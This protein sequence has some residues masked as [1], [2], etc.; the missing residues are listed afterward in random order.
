LAGIFTLELKQ[1]DFENSIPESWYCASVEVSPGKSNGN[2]T[3][4]DEN[5]IVSASEV[6]PSP[7]KPGD[8]VYLSEPILNGT[9][10]LT[11]MDASRHPLK[12]NQ[13]SFKMPNLSIGM[14]ILNY[15]NFD[16][17]VVRNKIMVR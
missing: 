8:L 15:T 10:V 9:L 6:F 5:P 2:F 14:Y 16:G 3:S 11:G 17:K 12:D 7:A 13:S 4:I 1:P